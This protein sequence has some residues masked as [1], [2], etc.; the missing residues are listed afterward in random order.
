[1]PKLNN[2]FTPSPIVAKA[3]RAKAVYGHVGEIARGV[4]L[5]LAKNPKYYTGPGTNTYLVGTDPVWIIDPGPDDPAHVNAVLA[6]VGERPVAGILVT[7][8]HMDHSPA[9]VPIAQKTGAKIYGFGSLSE[10][11]LSLTDEEVD[12]DFKPDIALADGHLIGEA[13][14]QIMALHTP[15]HFPNHMAFFVP[16]KGILFSGDHVMGWST[17]VVV[18]PLGNMAEYLSSLD[19]LERLGSHLMLPSHGL[20]VMDPAARICEVRQHRA[21]RQQQVEDCVAKGITDPSVIVSEIYE[22]LAEGLVLAAEGC[23]A[24]H[25]EYV[26]IEKTGQS[27]T[28]LVAEQAPF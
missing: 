10:D 8:T 5:V 25:L 28:S 2:M 12:P 4:E 15:G 7:H 9:A 1:M 17:T 19:K 20:A 13:D 6:A 23:V 3:L 24:A 11:I 14:W 18:P 27:R 22:D 26:D 16:Q 21:M